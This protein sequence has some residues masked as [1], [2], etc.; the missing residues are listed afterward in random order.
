MRLTNRAAWLAV[1]GI[2]FCVAACKPQSTGSGT[3]EENAERSAHK[4]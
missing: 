1:L 4:R 3:G 2:S